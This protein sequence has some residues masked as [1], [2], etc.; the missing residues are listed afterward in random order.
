MSL[1]NPPLSKNDFN[2]AC[3]QDVVNSS[4]R[5]DCFF[6]G[7]AFWKKSQEAQEVGN[8]REQAVFA[9][10]AAVTSAAIKPEST[11]DFFADIFKNLTD[12]Q[13]NFLAG[14]A[15][16][17]SDPELRARV[18]D[19]LWIR[20]RDYQMAQ[21]AIPAYLE[22]ATTLESPE[23]W[24]HCVDRMERALRLARK[25]RHKDEVVFSHIEAVVD[26]YNGEDPLWLSTKLME[27]LQEYRFGDPSKY[28]VLSERAATLAESSS[29][30]RRARTLWG[31]KAVWHRM[32]KDYSKELDAS[33]LAAETYVKEAQAAL[34]RTPPSYMV[35]SHFLQY[36]VEAFRSIRGTKQETVDAKARAEEVHKLLLQYQEETRNEMITSS[37][38]MDISELVE[39]ARNHV[40]GKD[41]QEALFA[42][43]L[44]G[45]PTDVSQLRQQVQQQAREFL[46][47]HLFP[48]VMMNETGKV[49]AR[50]S[51]SVLSSNPEEAEAAT[52]FEMCRNAIYYQNLQAQAYVEPARYQI[53][54]E[55]NVR[56][57]DILSIISH[58]PFIP[59]ER[60]YLFAKGLYAGL[61]GDFFTSTHI[62]IPQIENSVRYIMWRRG[63]ITSGLDDSGIQ[64]E[65]NLN[66][67]LYRPEITSI[68]DENTLFDLKCL[69]VEHAGSNLRNRMAHGLI[70]D[71]E[72]MSPLMSYIW[73]LT[74]RLCLLPILSGL[75]LFQSES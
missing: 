35:A 20:R 21:L 52:R 59:P 29:D 23:H 6:Y 61:T 66:F 74:W 33:M 46:V 60:E 70:S 56:L 3:W 13:L 39:K 73:W 62:L 53:N 26:R 58:S 63:I 50:Q 51:G 2:N 48:V 41:F 1:L 14:I 72:F 68:F 5:K 67:T 7:R 27:L 16:Q 45:A 19:I 42:L 12:D 22:S 57:N 28:A 47:S 4:E 55:H 37:H 24:T 71:G 54:L 64:N 44:L 17:I 36:A 25:I 49:T 11:E 18:A 9:V 31:I 34:T 8:F 15:P 38:A 10:L 69:L 43:A 32:D 30:W 65:H 40:R 75:P